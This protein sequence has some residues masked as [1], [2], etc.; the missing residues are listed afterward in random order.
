[1]NVREVYFHH[2]PI[3]ATQHRTF[4][5][6]IGS[7]RLISP[8]SVGTCGVGIK[9]GQRVGV[10]YGEGG[11]MIDERRGAFHTSAAAQRHVRAALGLQKQAH[12]AFGV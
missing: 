11:Q 6:G 12:A 10:F 8:L 3:F 7:R 4:G 2:R 9:C 5:E 1:M